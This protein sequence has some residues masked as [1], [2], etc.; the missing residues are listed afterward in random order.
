MFLFD[1]VVSAKHGA[2]T[3]LV[4]VFLSPAFAQIPS[5]IDLGPRP[6]GDVQ[7][8][9]ST[10]PMRLPPFTEGGYSFCQGA[11]GAMPVNQECGGPFHESAAVVGGNPPYHF[12]LEP[13][14]GFPP[15]GLHLDKDGNLR[16][17]ISRGYREKPFTVCAVDLSGTQSCQ[18]YVVP[19]PAAGARAGAREARRGHRGAIVGAL[20]AGGGAAAAGAVVAANGLGTSSGGSSG[21]AC[22]SGRNCIVNV[23]GSGCSCSQA[24]A[25]GSCSW[26]GTVAQSGQ[27]CGDGVP[28]ASGLSCNNGRCE[29]SGGRCPF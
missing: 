2:I 24:S 19:A 14:T 11:P 1:K 27:A 9:R 7:F 15:L 10:E 13:G 23:M 4:A 28:C 18:S 26:T 17:T 22:I 25:T 8:K 16:G 3:A 29:G 20:V 12:V 5:A 21:G 6:E